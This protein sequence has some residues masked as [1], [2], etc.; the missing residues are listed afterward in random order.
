ME[1]VCHVFQSTWLSEIHSGRLTLS[2]RLPLGFLL[3]EQT[4]HM[5]LS[6]CETP[7]MHTNEIDSKCWD[8][9]TSNQFQDKIWG[10]NRAFIGEPTSGKKCKSATR[11]IKHNIC[12][13]VT[14]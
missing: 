12:I 5:D 11:L 8:W 1:E 14:N 13:H 9:E 4:F 7:V 2:I 6:Q 3:V 10:F